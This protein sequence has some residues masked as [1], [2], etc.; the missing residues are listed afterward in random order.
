M[1]QS[2]Q[3]IKK[4][5]KGLTLGLLAAIIFFLL[6]AFLF[7]RITDEI[8]LEKETGFDMRV[9]KFLFQFT[10]PAATKV[11]LLFTFF[12]STKY[13]LPASNLLAGFFLFY[14][15]NMLQY[16]SVDAVGLSRNEMLYV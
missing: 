16:I 10:N 2:N 11:M 5:A 8:V 13:L 15:R 12:G 4:R 9:F 6:I 3:Q 14:K 1:N 7:W